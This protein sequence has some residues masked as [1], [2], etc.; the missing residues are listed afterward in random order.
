MRRAGRWA[1]NAWAGL[2]LVYLFAP[3]VVI[4]VF[5]FNDPRGDFNIVWQR[6]TFDNW[7]HPLAD[8]DLT[9]ALVVSLEVALIA[10]AAAAAM[11]TLVAVALARYRFRGGALVSLLLVLPLTTPEIVLGA[12][13]ATLLLDRGVQRG[14]WTIVIA[15]VMFCVSFVALTI[16]ARLRGFDWTLED[17][18]MDLGASP[19]R[20]FRTITLPLIAPGILA[21]A[22]LSFALSIDDFI[23]TFFNAGSVVTFPLQVYGASQREISPQ[24]NVLATMILLASVAAVVVGTVARSRRSAR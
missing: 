2:A 17:A 10:T 9:E 16:K 22:M 11:G 13:L 4:V 8:R 20:T 24:I 12:S 14:F 7:L 3:V 15:H 21:A 23:I 1:L 18:A 5:S 19:L 6:F